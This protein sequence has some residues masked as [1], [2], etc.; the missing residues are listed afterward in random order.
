MNYFTDEEDL[1]M[2]SRPGANN[3]CWQT[4]PGSQQEPLPWCECAVGQEK[5]PPFNFSV[6]YLKN[7]KEHTLYNLSALNLE[8]YLIRPLN[9]AR[10]GGWS[11]GERLSTE[12]QIRKG[13]K[14]HYMPVAKVWYNQK[15]F[16]ALPSYL[17]Q[18][19]NFILWKN[20]P[21]K[22][23]WKQYGITLYSCPYGG[24]LLD[25]DK[26][27]ENVRQCGVAL[28]I[29]LGFSILTASI[30]SSVV[31]DRVSGAKR[32]QHMSGLGYK[33][34]W[35]ANF[36]YDMLL[37]LVPVGLCVGIITVFQL[38]AFT[39]RDNLAAAALLLILFG[40]TTL[41]WMYLMS[42][43]FTSS[44]I[45]FISYISLNFVC[46]LCTMLVTLLPRLL[47]VIS[48]G[49]SF[50]NIYNILKWTFI[51]FP[52]FCLGQGLIE[53]AY[54][55][56]KFDLTSNFGINSYVTPFEM[57]FL[58]WIFTEMALQG[59][60]LLLLRILLNWDLL[61]KP[62]GHR[63]TT[64][65]FVPPSEDRDVELER[66][67]L[68]GGANASDLLLLYNLQ[69]SY[70]GFGKRNTA[71]KGITLGIQRG[72]CFGL[73]GVNGAGKSTTFKMLTGDVIPSAGR[74]VIQTSAGS[75]LDI[76]SALLQGVR[77]GYCPQQDALDPL[78]TGWEHLYYYCSLRGI[79]KRQVHK[80]AGELVSRLHLEAQASELVR[81]Y[82]GGTKRKLSTALALVGKPHV[83]LLDEPSSGMDPCSKRFLWNTIKMEVQD[84]CAAILTSHSMEECEALCTRLAIMVN[85]SFKCL[86]SPQHIKNRFG[87][88]HS[89]KVWLSKETSNHNAVTECLRLHFPG[90]L[91]K[92]QHV[93]L[94]EY[95]VPQ[96]WGCLAELLAVLE[97]NKTSLQIKHYS[98]SQTTLEQVFINFAAEDQEDSNSAQG[99]CPSHDPHLPL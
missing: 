76:L 26:I 96:N 59:T 35:F 21:S 98:I 18:L 52:Q 16:H 99:S 67:R 8:E 65:A 86:G 2:H 87:D 5:C 10:F 54:N 41:P 19:N 3:A 31:K 47:A 83:L 71:V 9:K 23:D 28:C 36:L 97:S 72:E 13:R 20:L 94:L 81:T 70:Q 45:A 22:A 38:S 50:Q 40:Y 25:E 17:N 29:V 30:G 88:G 60:L 63:H 84:G 95:H 80:V 91:F 82:S 55:Q 78:L 1:C 69:K 33:T 79:P 51:I 44:D 27:M 14:S 15:G 42:R 64:N 37:Y 11:F 74:A 92:G 73:L 57:N 77:I 12:P 75:E 49:Q 68:F 32:L 90:T 39:F 7:K 85:G 56:I 66:K 61:Q 34:Y 6:S 4:T 24:A 62:R 93:N 46:G 43:F 89:V 53:L 48:R 58:G